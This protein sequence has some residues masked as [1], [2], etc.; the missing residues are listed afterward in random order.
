MAGMLLVYMALQ[1]TLLRHRLRGIPADAAAGVQGAVLFGMVVLIGA[2]ARRRSRGTMTGAL[3]AQ[4]LLWGSLLTL[5]AVTV[6][7]FVEMF[8]PG[9]VMHVPL[10][11]VPGLLVLLTVLSKLILIMLR[12]HAK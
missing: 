1:Q 2:I 8:A 11:V 9:A 10:L 7:G 6:W 4:A 5:L 12:W 3:N